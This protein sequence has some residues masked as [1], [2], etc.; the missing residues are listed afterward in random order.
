MYVPIQIWEN[1]LIWMV[2]FNFFS[3]DA[4]TQ[5]T[6]THIKQEF[7]TRRVHLILAAPE[8]HEMNG[9]V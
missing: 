4:G 7:Q 5:C 6:L 3:E 2:G 1:V 8:H 9:Q